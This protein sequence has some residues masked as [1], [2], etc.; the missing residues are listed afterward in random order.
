MNFVRKYFWKKRGP[1]KTS[2]ATP[3]KPHVITGPLTLP[4]LREAATKRVHLISKE[5]G[6]CFDLLHGYPLSVTFFGSARV[7][8]SDPNY[9]K[10]ERLGA[11]IAKEL[12][13]S[14]ITGGGPG[15]M[16][17]ANRGAFEAKGDSVGITIRLPNEQ[18]TNP[19]I[20][21]KVDM[22]YFFDR[23]VCLSFSAEA[24]IFFP[25]GFGT[26]DELFEILT[27]VQTGKITALPIILVDSKFW[28]PIFETIKKEILERK[29]ISEEDL[30][31][32][33]I[34]DDEDKI[35]DIIKKAPVRNG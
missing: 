5:F 1:Q 27:L 4:E 25:G 6:D 20:T 11:R 15:I 9:Q 14:V 33:T 31:I 17:A 21:N 35:I 16:A 7:S 18:V 26:L 3:E 8:E 32:F 29:M 28:I 10:A 23:K 30:N 12:K 2:K 34:E 13:Y 22:T 24:Y 19:Y